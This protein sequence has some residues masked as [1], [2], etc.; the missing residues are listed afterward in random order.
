MFSM[1]QSIYK[2]SDDGEMENIAATSIDNIPEAVSV[3]MES[4]D[5]DEIELDGPGKFIEKCGYDILE[6]LKQNYTNKNVRINLNG[7]L[8]N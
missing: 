2:V 8:L 4:F 7:T 5:V 6:E 3:L 1:S